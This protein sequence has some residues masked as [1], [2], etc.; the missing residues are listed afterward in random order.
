MG[1]RCDGAISRL[2]GPGEMATAGVGEEDCL[3]TG[4]GS[5][6]AA[7]GEPEPA[8]RQESVRDS[9]GAN[10]TA[11]KL[12][13]G[14]FTIKQALSESD[15]PLHLT[16]PVRA[17]YSTSPPL[18]LC[19]CCCSRQ[20]DKLSSHYVQLHHVSR[21]FRT[22]VIIPPA[23]L[24]VYRNL[25]RGHQVRMRGMCASASNVPRALDS[26][27][28]LCIA[29]LHHRASPLSHLFALNGIADEH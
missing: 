6:G 15:P 19:H 1:Y 20:H 22:R 28:S 3:R 11:H 4:R 25:Q 21:I 5:D 12:G 8:P 9:T 24:N 7:S 26:P 29:A 18:S 13:L 14:P 17:Y 27:A 23:N 2:A 10:S 16:F